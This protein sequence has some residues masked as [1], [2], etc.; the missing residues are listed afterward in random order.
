MISKNKKAIQVALP[1]ELIDIM[2]RA[3]KNDKSGHHVTKSEIITSALL[4]L[5][6]MAE[7]RAK[8]QTERETKEE[9]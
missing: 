9:A 2:E 7:E 6:G 5:F 1:I 3:I 8:K 4:L